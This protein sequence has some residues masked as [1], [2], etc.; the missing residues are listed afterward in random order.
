[1]DFVFDC[2]TYLVTQPVILA[3]YLGELLCKAR[4]RGPKCVKVK[5]ALFEALLFCHQHRI[6][7]IHLSHAPFK[8]LLVLDQFLYVGV[9]FASGLL[10]LFVF[11][12]E[13]LYEG[14]KTFN[15]FLDS[16]LIRVT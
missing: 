7:L 15:N 16:V 5:L 8:R 3:A 11:L 2:Y 1:M 13:V 4:K 14:I 10:D 6:H 12:Q 9:D